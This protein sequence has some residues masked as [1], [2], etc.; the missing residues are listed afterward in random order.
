MPGPVRMLRLFIVTTALV[1]AFWVG[2]GEA[3]GDDVGVAKGEV[4][5]VLPAAEV[6]VAGVAVGDSSRSGVC[7]P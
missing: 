3:S 4:K 7:S 2:V 6:G 5:E 1:G